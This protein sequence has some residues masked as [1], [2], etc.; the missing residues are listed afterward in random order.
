MLC[1]S[2]TCTVGRE[3]LLGQILK[4]QQGLSGFI[5]ERHQ[6][7]GGRFHYPDRD[8][9]ANHLSMLWASVGNTMPGLSILFFSPYSTSLATFW[10][11]YYLLNAPE[12]L[13]AVR[14]EIETVL[15]AKVVC[16]LFIS[17]QLL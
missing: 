16:F 13:A 10:V 14:E 4:Y 9:Q 3:L 12:A 8:I 11:F 7:L 5:Q 15:H 2:D 6:L 1:S 17:S